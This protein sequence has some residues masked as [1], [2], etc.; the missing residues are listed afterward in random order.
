VCCA[1][2]LLA[3]QCYEV[4]Y[5]EETATAVHYLPLTRINAAQETT[6]P[7][8]LV[9]SM[10]KALCC[11]TGIE[12]ELELLG[13]ESIAG[14]AAGQRAKLEQRAGSREQGSSTG[15]L[16]GTDQSITGHCFYT[17]P[18][19]DTDRHRHAP[20]CVKRKSDSTMTITITITIIANMIF[21]QPKF[22]ARL[23]LFESSSDVS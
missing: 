3:L 21:R 11:L 17:V 1:R 23:I 10:R 2:S 19:T 7:S 12:P 5:C 8:V 15:L 9:K 22:F 20:T 18:I 4:Q 13:A 14:I 16:L 6:S